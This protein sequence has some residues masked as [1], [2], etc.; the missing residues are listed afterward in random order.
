M[1]EKKGLKEKIKKVLKLFVEVSKLFVEEISG[2]RETKDN[3][4]R[5]TI[6]KNKSCRRHL[7]KVSPSFF[8]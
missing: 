5:R 3:V 1:I 7:K 8:Y 4:L 6:E 2:T